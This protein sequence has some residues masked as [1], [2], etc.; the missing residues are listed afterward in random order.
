MTTKPPS[1]LHRFHDSPLYDLSIAIGEG[2]AVPRF[3]G[4]G[5]NDITD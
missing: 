4:A 1:F 2:R 3:F 5:E